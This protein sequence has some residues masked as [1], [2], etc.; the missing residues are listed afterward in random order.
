MDD[1]VPNVSTARLQAMGPTTRTQPASPRPRARSTAATFF[2]ASR[3]SSSAEHSETEHDLADTYAFLAT[4]L[5][6]DAYTLSEM[7]GSQGVSGHELLSAS[8]ISRWT[9]QGSSR[10]S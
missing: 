2:A 3:Q 7:D 10:S 5:K 4:P 1:Y 8:P 6:A 9:A